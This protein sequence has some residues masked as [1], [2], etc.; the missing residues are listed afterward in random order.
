MN[1]ARLKAALNHV[2]PK[3]D[4]ALAEKALFGMERRRQRRIV[5]RGGGVVAIAVAAAVT[6]VLVLPKE[7]EKV[8]VASAPRTSDRPAIETDKQ[9][10]TSRGSFHLPDGT[11]GVP[12]D[13]RSKLTVLATTDELVSVRVDEG[14]C[15]FEVTPAFDRVF[16]V[17]VGRV[18]ITVLGTEF[19]AELADDRARVKVSRGRVLVEW[20]GG[21]DE[22]HAGQEG[23]YPPHGIGDSLDS[24]IPAPA[25]KGPRRDTRPDWWHHARNGEFDEAAKA[26]QR[27][28]VVR[29][30]V[31]DLL[32]AADAMRLSGHPA[33]ALPFLERVTKLHRDDPRGPL[34][35]FTRGRLLLLQL[36]RPRLAATAFRSARR[37]APFGN[38]AQ[39]ALARE[40]EAWHRAG[41]A[42]TARLL[43]EKYL[44]KYPNGRRR[45]AVR[46][47]GGLD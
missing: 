1:D 27:S 21:S 34:A 36:G 13:D 15:N 38:L 26:L 6:L 28:E 46:R 9:L 14:L 4:D 33:L 20:P 10:L 35:E 43:A 31:E 30:T 8:S 16:R 23:V 42:A 12:A 18:T 45:R 41:E 7:Q 47:F 32:L 2:Q 40:V 44:S 37:L 17:K 3:W 5:A 22:L 25:K 19:L 29:D 11:S 24:G 39:D